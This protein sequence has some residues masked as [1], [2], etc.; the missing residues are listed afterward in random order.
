M[1]KVRAVLM[2]SDGH[3]GLLITRA[4]KSLAATPL[5]EGQ[6]IKAIDAT[7]SDKERFSRIVVKSQVPGS[8]D[9]DGDSARSLSGVAVDPEIKRYRPL[10]VMAETDLNT[11]Q[12]QERANWEVSTRRGKGTRVEVTVQGW[13]QT[14]GQLWDINS[15]VLLRS[16]SVRLNRQM[17]IAAT[18]FTLDNDGGHITRLS[19]VRPEAYELIAFPDPKT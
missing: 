10:I 5:V 7:F 1:A 8:D 6:N 14:N 2:M 9:I 11:K 16:P 4:G 3:G 15:L 19:L 12:C 13:R 17:L 18:E